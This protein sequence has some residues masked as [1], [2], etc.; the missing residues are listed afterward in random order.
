MLSF[1]HLRLHSNFILHAASCNCSV[2]SAG[3]AQLHMPQSKLT[4][5]EG[6]ISGAFEVALVTQTFKRCALHGNQGGT[7][8]FQFLSVA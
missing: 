1:L 5:L 8:W 7:R 6:A 4:K 3:D 2:S